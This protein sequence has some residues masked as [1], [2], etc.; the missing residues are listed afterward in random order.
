MVG[1]AVVSGGIGHEQKKAS[2]CFRLTGRWGISSYKG[3]SQSMGLYLS[4][5]AFSVRLLEFLLENA[6]D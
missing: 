6:A 3:G 1:L 4:Q 5:F 2:P